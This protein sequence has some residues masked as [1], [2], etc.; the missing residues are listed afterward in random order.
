MLE[1]PFLNTPVP[2]TGTDGITH[3]PDRVSIRW[4]LDR[5]VDSAISGD[6]PLH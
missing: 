1:G 2:L 4:T 3:L 5:R 6:V